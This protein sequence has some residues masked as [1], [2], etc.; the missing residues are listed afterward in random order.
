M[1]TLNLD[2]PPHFG[3]L[4]RRQDR[5]LRTGSLPVFQNHPTGELHL[6]EL[7]EGNAIVRLSEIYKFDQNLRGLG[8]KVE[9]EKTGSPNLEGLTVQ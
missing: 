8:E 7:V 5:T 3:H 1:V 6:G 4:D 9:T 2:P